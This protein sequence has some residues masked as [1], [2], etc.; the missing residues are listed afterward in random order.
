MR[1][2]A[3]KYKDSALAGTKPYLPVLGYIL[4]ALALLYPVTVLGEKSDI[5]NE[6]RVYIESDDGFYDLSGLD[7]EYN[8]YE[9]FG[10]E[11][12]P[13]AYLLPSELDRV[14][15]ETRTRDAEYCTVHMSVT[16]PDDEAY[17]LNFRF[18]GSTYAGR[19]YINGRLELTSGW[20]GTTLSETEAVKGGYYDRY[21]LYAAPKDGKIDIVCHFANFHHVETGVGGF[22]LFIA[23]SGFI[24]KYGALDR[25]IPYRLVII[26]ALF[27]L[28]LLLFSI[29]LTHI[30]TTQ[31]LW[32]ALVVFV[33]AVRR[34]LLAGFGPALFSFLPGPQ[35]VRLEYYTAPAITILLFLY[36]GKAFPGLYQRFFKWFTCLGALGYLSIAIFATNV[37]F[38][39]RL[40]FW[41]PF[42]TLFML[43]TLARLLWRLRKP[44][45]DQ[46]IAVTGYIVLV[47]ANCLLGFLRNLKVT[48]ETDKQ[49]PARR[50]DACPVHLPIAWL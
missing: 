16:T 30:K 6:H 41:Y 25:G 1:K 21:E 35:I 32:F 45:N 23:K 27:G 46:A 43:Y 47:I 12:Y 2:L 20:P 4:L 5:G 7:F 3:A 44:A 33:M 11:Y 19:V 17:I 9:L 31:N 50:A 26:G 10:A 8:Y 36:M 22:G 39:W 15:S 29:W 18:P 24:Q 40:Q 42:F 28:A 38:T 49:K 14:K 34:C 13:A 48:Y 37:F